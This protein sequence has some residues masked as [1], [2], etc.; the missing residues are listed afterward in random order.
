MAQAQ[1]QTARDIGIE[2][3][4]PAQSCTDRACPFH[5]HLKVRGQV[6]TGRIVSAK[7]E[8][9]VV[10]EREL[11]HYNNKFERYERRTRRYSARLPSCLSG[12]AGDEVRIMECR[13]LSKTI[14]FCVV[15]V[16]GGAPQ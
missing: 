13:P 9:S 10:V 16:R 12:K 11:L 8:H 6:L 3:P 5:G 15:E 7:M 14:S 1:V 4:P 2:V